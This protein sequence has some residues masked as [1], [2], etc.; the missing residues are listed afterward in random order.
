[1]RQTVF[2]LATV[3]GTEESSGPCDEVS[4]DFPLMF[5]QL[6]IL[7]PSSLL[8]LGASERADTRTGA[9]EVPPSRGAEDCRTDSGDDAGGPRGSSRGGA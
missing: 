6:E 8:L 5:D 7:T 9:G 3:V 1:M 4:F 2:I